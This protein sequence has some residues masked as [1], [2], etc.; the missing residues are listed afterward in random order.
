VLVEPMNGR[1]V[2]MIQP[3]ENLR[4]SYKPRQSSLVLNEGWRQ[5]LD[6]HFSVKFRIRR[7]IHLSNP[8]L[9]KIGDGPEVS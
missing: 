3:R 8:A 7:Q 2:R 1:D 9:P 5:H 4:L 6:R